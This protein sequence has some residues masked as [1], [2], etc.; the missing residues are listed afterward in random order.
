MSLMAVKINLK[1]I[2]KMSNYDVDRI[3]NFRWELF[4]ERAKF[5]K[6]VAL[7]NDLTKVAMH[8]PGDV[9]LGMTPEEC[10]NELAKRLK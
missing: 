10:I 6:L 5:R 9:S 3:E 7:V 4:D 8:V 2:R 1:G